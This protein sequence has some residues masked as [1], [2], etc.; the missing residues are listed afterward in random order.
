M[1]KILWVSRRA[2]IMSLCVAFSLGMVLFS[3]SGAS[4]AQDGTTATQAEKTMETGLNG[5][6]QKYRYD[7]VD[8]EKALSERAMGDPDA[9]IVMVEFSSL[10]CPHCADFHEKTLP[11]LKEKYIDTGKVRLVMR[12]FPLDRAAMY[13]TL[14]ARCAPEQRYFGLMDLLFRSQDRWLADEKTMLKT[15]EQTGRLAGVGKQLFDACVHHEELEEAMYKRIRKA[16]TDW[17]IK[18]T[19]TFIFNEG[20]AK[21]EGSL[22]YEEFVKTIE[23]LLAEE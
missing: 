8:V 19:P 17:R 2:A 6:Q 11:R 7:L 4:F 9:P 14:M 18:S 21:I 1:H 15:L 5:T 16:S 20:E 22:P 10:S 3:A 23:G 13:A 12:E